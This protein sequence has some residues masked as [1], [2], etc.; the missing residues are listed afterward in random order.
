M[1]S[2]VNP[3]LI[4]VITLLITALSLSHAYA[5]RAFPDVT[6]NLTDNAGVLTEEEK[7]SL[8]ADLEFLRDFHYMPGAIVI[9]EKT[10]EWDFIE[11]GH[12]LFDNLRTRGLLDES[13]FLIYLSTGDRKMAFILGDDIDRVID[14]GE[15]RTITNRLGAS[16]EDGAFYYGLSRTLARLKALPGPADLEEARKQR[17]QWAIVAG[18]VILIAVFYL[19][20]SKKRRR[21]RPEE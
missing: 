13:S 15:K 21:G 17:G 11:Y 18:L 14:P 3:G 6:T 1:G 9:T 16:L 2:R 7:L 10:D 8:A 19:N 12:D 20:L 4:L 5:Q